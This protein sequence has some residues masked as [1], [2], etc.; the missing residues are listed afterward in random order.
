MRCAHASPD[1]FAGAGLAATLGDVVSVEEALPAGVPA[2]ELAATLG[3]VAGVDEAAGEL[4][5]T[6]PDVAGVAE[7]ASAGVPAGDLPVGDKGAVTA[8]VV[9]AFVPL[10]FVPVGAPLVSSEEFLGRAGL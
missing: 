4:T 3:D 6:L 7:A 9:P 8:D 10:D 5:E 2:G 1:D